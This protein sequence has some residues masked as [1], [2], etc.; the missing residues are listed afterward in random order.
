ML[1]ILFLVFH[2]F[3]LNTESLLFLLC[4][5]TPPTTVPHCLHSF[6]LAHIFHN[7]LYISGNI[8]TFLGCIDNHSSC[9]PLLSD[10]YNISWTKSLFHSDGCIVVW[11]S[12]SSRSVHH[13]D[14]FSILIETQTSPLLFSAIKSSC[15]PSEKKFHT[16]ESLEFVVAQFSRNSWVP[17]V[18]KFTSSTKQ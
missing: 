3:T 4:N 5:I 7:C 17:L 1:P 8:Q 9:P 16:V 11:K 6:H 10:C 15:S 14:C 18:H 12:H 2:R 13:D